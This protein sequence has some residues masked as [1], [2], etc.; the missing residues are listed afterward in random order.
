[1]G[2]DSHKDFMLSVLA[3][4]EK[5]IAEAAKAD[6]AGLQNIIDLLKSLKQTSDERETHLIDRRDHKEQEMLDA[7][8]RMETAA[9]NLLDS[10]NE[11]DRLSDAL[12]AAKAYVIEK[13]QELTHAESQHDIS[14]ASMNEAEENAA[15]GQAEID[16]INAALQSILETIGWLN[17]QN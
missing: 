13:Q 2:A 15:N 3:N 7:K 4:P 17:G 14:T 10:E 11:H 16:Q 9:N 12:A 6:S 5:F 8:S 1:M